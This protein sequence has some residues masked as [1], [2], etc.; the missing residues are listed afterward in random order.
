MRKLSLNKPLVVFDIE[1]TGPNPRVDRIIEIACVKLL[2]PNG[3]TRETHTFRV[4]P[5]IPIPPDSIAFHCITSAMVAESPPFKDIAPQL[6]KL[7]EGCDIA[8][9][10]A[11]KMDIPMLVEE[12]LRVGIKFDISNRRIIDA[13][14]IYHK[15]ESRDLSAA[16]KFF[17]GD[18]F[19][20]C[21]RTEHSA[22]AALS[23]LEGQLQHYPD[24]PK[25]MDELAKYCDI[26][27]PRWADREG[28]L[29]WENGEL[30]I[31]FGKKK[32]EMIRTLVQT[33]P[34]FLKWMLRGDFASDTKS[35]ITACMAGQIVSPQ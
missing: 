23:V 7:L 27:D 24:L 9:F 34:G 6:I 25:N 14:R 26:R 10:G 8:G 20:D 4:N 29:A 31:N 18:D 5:G 17:C 2:P 21:H 32:G 3:E 33:D 35:Y 22:L 28:K 30:V 19:L 1:S 11:I 13:Q 16:V 15:N 12:F